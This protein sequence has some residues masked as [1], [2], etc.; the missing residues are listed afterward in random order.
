M[1]NK[2]VKSET[3]PLSRVYFPATLALLAALTLSGCNLLDE[4]QFMPHG[5]CLAWDMPLLTTF[6]IGNTLV[7]TSYYSIPAAL[8][9]FISKRKDLAFNWMFKLFAAFI[10]WCGTTHVLKLW[11]FWHATYWLEAAADLL[12]GVLSFFTAI[13]LWKLIPR[14]LL[15]R[16]PT[17]WER[18][19]EELRETLRMRNLSEEA[20]RES[21]ETTSKI[22][23]KASDCFVAIDE[24]GKIVDW[25]VQ[26]EATF[27]WK[28]EEVLGL[29]L[30]DTIIPSRM[31]DLHTQGIANHGKKGTSNVIN[32][33]IEVPAVNKLGKEF[34]V[35]LAVFPVQAAGK[36][37]FCA[38]V[39]DITERRR[40]EDT[41][42]L[43]RDQALDASKFKSEFLANMSHEI[44]TPMNGILGMAEILMESAQSERDRHYATTIHDAGKSLLTVLND[45]L[46]FSKIEAG[47]L[48]LDSHDFDVVRLVESV[49]ELF[50]N[51]AR[52]K[53]L[54]IASLI[55]ANIPRQILGD[56][57]RIRQ[58]LTNFVGNA[59]K[60]SES[61]EV[62]IKVTL[63]ESKPD[64][65]QL[66]FIVKD[67]G[68]GLSEDEISQL[69]QPFVQIDGSLTRSHGGTGL[70]LSISKRL[71][72]LMHGAIGVESSRG[73]GASFWFSVPL[74][75][76]KA[77]IIESEDLNKMQGLRI[78]VVDD[79]KTSQTVMHEYLRSWGI[80]D[81][82]ADSGKSALEKLQQCKEDEVYSV[83]LIDM[84]MPD[85]DGISLGR[86]ILEKPGLEQMKLVLITAFDRPG[87]GEEAIQAGFSGYLVKPLKQSQLL[88]CLV[89]V[90][91]KNEMHMPDGKKNRAVAQVQ[92]GADTKK[93][94]ERILIVEDHKINQE[95]AVLQ[96][97]NMGFE[98]EVASTGK[99]ALQ[100][101]Q[102]NTYS[103]ILMDCQMPEMD[104][105]EAARNIRKL[106]EH[107]GKRV[108]IIAITAHA[109]DGSR[110][111]CVSAGMDDYLSKPVD[112]KKLTVLV[113]KW[114]NVKS[115]ANLNAPPVDLKTLETNMGG[116]PVKH[117]I[118]LFIEET[119]GQLE[120]LEAALSAQDQ[121]QLALD[122][123]GLKGDS[124]SIYS[125]ELVA[126][127]QALEE[128]AKRKDWQKC[129]S[130][131][132]E[133]TRQIEAVRQF[134]ET[135][136]EDA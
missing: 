97:R 100:M 68:I 27:L 95:V 77:P 45:I 111:K 136:P 74:M 76:G 30:T 20:L 5:C 106:E 24:E 60:F 34:P 51:Q 81:E 23:E 62:L 94:S 49:T 19:N 78:L 93:R 56:A 29:K 133:I 75:A 122:A 115:Q 41:I 65:P 36:K 32:K 52:T 42:K 72:E 127:S 61:G 135:V 124:A 129:R 1:Q 119:K 96:L 54:T 67:T 130:T 39:H 10:F 16:S 63:D 107:S 132:D 103:L 2:H 43:A 64:D 3:G 6:V 58:V 40:A 14:L 101:V 35:E 90:L 121:E 8:W 53:G 31:G 89:T 109:L 117:L 113:D 80:R 22:I 105:F 15:L 104:G 88:D 92:S 85:T 55:E 128:S 12:T 48:L 11:T 102:D 120:R 44:R 59:I 131:L 86:Q 66:K 98:A 38:F 125:K 69:F 71:V 28:K 110:E 26:A 9:L 4:K 114:L 73:K 47:K 99:Q 57:G 126:L 70:G 21:Q 134:A 118:L 17:D 84:I 116:G 33:R 18:A 108:P 13:L 82:I 37:L 87:I 91:N 50:S 25:N 46:D 112:V 7:F 83:A 79:Q 123:H